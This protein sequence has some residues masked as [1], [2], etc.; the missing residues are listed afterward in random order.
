MDRGLAFD[1]FLPGFGGKYRV[2]LIRDSALF[3]GGFCVRSKGQRV[4]VSLE[5]IEDGLISKEEFIQF[6]LD[7]EP[8]LEANRRRI[9]GQKTCRFGRFPGSVDSTL[10]RP[11][12]LMASPPKIVSP[13]GL[14]DSCFLSGSL[15]NWSL[16]EKYNWTGHGDCPLCLHSWPSFQLG[17]TDWPGQAAAPEGFVGGARR[18]GRRP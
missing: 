13:C 11:C 2:P 4:A 7:L 3:L 12:C 6:F 5:S 16:V 1:S 10:D 17:W 9:A 18:F 14:V 8:L 15:N